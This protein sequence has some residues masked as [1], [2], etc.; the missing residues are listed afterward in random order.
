MLVL[1]FVY[2]INWGKS[3]LG[4]QKNLNNLNQSSP[5]KY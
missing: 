5:I 4:V 1:G 2:N 3:P